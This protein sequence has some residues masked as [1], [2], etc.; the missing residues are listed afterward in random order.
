LAGNPVTTAAGLACLGYLVDHPEIYD[1]LEAMGARIES[2]LTE[3]LAQRSVPGCVQRVG[4]MLT[5]FF[6]P[7]VVRSW[8]DAITA[9]RDAFGRFFRAAYAGGV[10]LPPSQFESLFLMED[11]AGELDRAIETLTAAIG[12]VR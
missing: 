12:A 7:T 1:Q 4:A 10:L 11:H 3:A 5:V 8:D 9:D 6:G 2:A